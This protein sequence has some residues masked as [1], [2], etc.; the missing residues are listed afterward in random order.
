MT[1]T[2]TPTTKPPA[3]SKASAD[4]VADIVR[5]QL[6][7]TPATGTPTGMNSDQA[8][9]ML[10]ELAKLNRLSKLA[11]SRLITHP[12]QTIALGILLAAALMMLIGFVYNF[13]V[14][15]VLEYGRI[16]DMHNG[17]PASGWPTSR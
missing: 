17:I 15:S 11:E 4:A 1:S 12:R 14:G 6:A 7:A 5:Q 2:S 9:R 13:L 3:L 8:E 10:D 16:R